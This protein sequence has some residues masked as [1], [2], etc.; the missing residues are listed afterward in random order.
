MFNS[1]HNK[2]K[3][4]HSAGRRSHQSVPAVKVSGLTANNRFFFHRSG[5]VS[6]I[7]R[8]AP[9]GDVSSRRRHPAHLASPETSAC[10]GRHECYIAGILVRC[11]PNCC[12]SSRCDCI[13]GTHTP[14]N[15]VYCL[16]TVSEMQYPQILIEFNNGKR[17]FQIEEYKTIKKNYSYFKFLPWYDV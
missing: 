3:R 11:L 14:R 2:S 13:V 15:N 17:Q 16:G 10:G 1:S 7:S 9:V 12:H 6:G 8:T 5:P 4:A